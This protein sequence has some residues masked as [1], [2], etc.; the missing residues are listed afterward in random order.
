MSVFADEFRPFWLAGMHKVSGRQQKGL[1]GLLA[2]RSYQIYTPVSPTMAVLHFQDWEHVAS[3]FAADCGRMSSATLETVEGITQSEALP[4]S[5]GWLMVRG[6]YAAFFAAHSVER[7]LGRSISQLDGSATHAVDT[8]ASAF[9]MLSGGNLGRGTFVCVANS[10]A[11][12]LTLQKTYADGAHEALWNDF[13]DLLRNVTAKML[14]QSQASAAAQRVVGKLVELETSLTNSGAI[15]GG[16]W[17][18]LVRNRVNYQ[19]TFGAWFPYRERVA[20][21]DKLYEK[22]DGWR[23]DPDNLSIWPQPG[24]DVQRFIETC[25]MLVAICREL[26]TDMAKRCPV[27]KSFHDYASVGLM[28]HLNI[29]SV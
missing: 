13:I 22:M 19:H 16:N 23:K 6:Y 4:K 25:A 24:R 17:L 14:G 3:A 1:L 27:G 20:Y 21:Y 26:C 10:A 15:E 29:Q 12:T 11:Q 7:M 2:E 18:S 9:G 28:R 8:V 5:A